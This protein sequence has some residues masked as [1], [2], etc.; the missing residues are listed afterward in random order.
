[1]I[2]RLL[3]GRS[4]STLTAGQALQVAQTVAQ[5]SGGGPGV[6]D[7][8]RRSLGVDALNIGTDST[9][10]GGQIGAGKRLNDKI[11]VGVQQGTTPDSS[12]VTVDVD[13]TRNIRIQGAAGAD[14]SNEL[15]I[16]AQWDY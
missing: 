6:V 4:I 3:F 8:I 12:K 16:G 5:F 1:V 10:K 7:S 13:V 15:G 14:G 11:Y 9:G 2:A